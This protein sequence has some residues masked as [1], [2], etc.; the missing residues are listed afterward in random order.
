[1][2][3]LFLNALFWRLFF[4]RALSWITLLDCSLSIPH[5]C[6]LELLLS[7]E[8][9]IGRAILSIN[10][11][12]STHISN[13]MSKFFTIFQKFYFKNYQVII[14]IPFK[15][16]QSY[17]KKD[18]TIFCCSFCCLWVSLLLF[19]HP[20]IYSFLYIAFRITNPKVYN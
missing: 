7:P 13:L 12:R 18:S 19:R 1:M 16:L 5:L 6:F 14:W 15:N 2:D 11:Q 9:K 4:W 17:L 10:F 8:F 20:Q 3:A